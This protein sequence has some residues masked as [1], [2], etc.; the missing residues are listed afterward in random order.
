MHD[1]QGVNNLGGDHAKVSPISVEVFTQHRAQSSP[2]FGQSQKRLLCLA[3][4]LLVFI[5]QTDARPQ[6]PQMAVQIDVSLFCHFTSGLL[7]RIEHGKAAKHPR[8]K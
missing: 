1:N 3:V 5:V 2:A 8:K 4:V 6:V 7:E